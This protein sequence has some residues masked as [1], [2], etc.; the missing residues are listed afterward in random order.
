MSN[1]GIC[2]IVVWSDID[3]PD[4]ELCPRLAIG[5]TGSNSVDELLNELMNVVWD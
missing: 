2:V 1:I 5:Y 4:L 3:D